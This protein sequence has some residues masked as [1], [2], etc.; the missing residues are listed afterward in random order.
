MPGKLCVGKPTNN[1][2]AGNLRE[3]KAYCEGM[4]YRAS[5]ALLTVPITDNPHFNTGSEAEDSWNLGWNIAD[6]SAPSE[7]STSDLA[8]CATVGLVPA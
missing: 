3:S 5:G 4:A 8:C 6:S 1:I 7:V 2:G